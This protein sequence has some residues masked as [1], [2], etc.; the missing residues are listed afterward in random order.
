MIT[1]ETIRRIEQLMERAGLQEA[2][3]EEAF[4]LGSGAGGQK[5]NKTASCAVAS[6]AQRHG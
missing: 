5:I 3:L 4:V 2:D 1:P 6:C